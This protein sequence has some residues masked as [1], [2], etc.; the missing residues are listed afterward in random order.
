MSTHIPHYEISHYEINNK[1]GKNYPIFNAVR[2]QTFIA[3][4]RLCFMHG[5]CY[6]LQGK[7]KP[8]VAAY[9]GVITGLWAYY[10]NNLFVQL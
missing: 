4:Y 9:D 2:Y 3:R 10:S 7:E 6:P 5:L 1:Q 8:L